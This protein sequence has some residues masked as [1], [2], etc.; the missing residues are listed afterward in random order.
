MDITKFLNTKKRDLSNNSNTEEGAKRQR[1]EYSSESLNVSILDTLKAPG[2]VFEV[3]LKSE[4]CVKILLSCLRNLEKEAI[5]ISTS[6]HFPSTTTKLK[7]K[8]S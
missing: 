7:A 3:S 8:S 1:E 5:K 2:D 4:N 6:W